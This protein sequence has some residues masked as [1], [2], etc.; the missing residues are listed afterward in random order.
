MKGQNAFLW[1]LYGMALFIVALPHALLFV[2]KSIPKTSDIGP[3]SSN[4]RIGIPLLHNN[5][6]MK[7]C[8]LCAEEV[9]EA[10]QIC[11]FCRHEFSVNTGVKVPALE[12][13][14]GERSDL[15]DVDQ[16][17]ITRSIKLTQDSVTTIKQAQ[18]K[19]F[20]V[21]YWPDSNVFIRKGKL[22]F[23]FQNNS[24]ILNFSSSRIFR[25]ASLEQ[26]RPA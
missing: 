3:G 4:H 18:E 10:A 2:P 9:R 7:T 21:E 24:D 11:R 23:S 15:S 6:Q 13:I 22:S 16:W 17:R 26:S 12:L 5:I 8:P 14:G 1:W 19:G 20:I 25:L